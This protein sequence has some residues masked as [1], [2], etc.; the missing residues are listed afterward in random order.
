MKCLWALPWTYRC[1]SFRASGVWITCIACFEGSIV[2]TRFC[3]PPT[4]LRTIVQLWTVLYRTATLCLIC[5]ENGPCHPTADVMTTGMCTNCLFSRIS[6]EMHLATTWK[7]CSKSGPGDWCLCCLDT[8]NS[9][10]TTRALHTFGEGVLDVHSWHCTHKKLWTV[11]V[12]RVKKRPTWWPVASDVVL[13][14]MV[15]E[16]G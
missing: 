1:F 3:M 8:L 7:S 9:S 13:A 12:R 4:R 2:W 5:L 11:F 15:L 16:R 6:R 10:N 14:F